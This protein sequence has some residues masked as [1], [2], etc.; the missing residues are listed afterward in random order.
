MADG[1][2][3]PGYDHRLLSHLECRY[4]GP[5]PKEALLWA[6]RDPAS[7]QIAR[8]RG[9]A[10]AFRR[11]AEIAILILRRHPN[12]DMAVGDLLRFRA[13]FR[14][15]NRAA[16]RLR[17]HQ[18]TPLP[19]TAE[20]YHSSLLDAILGPDPAGSVRPTPRAES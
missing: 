10:H 12:D 17:R 15:W 5:I 8:F 13:A 3:L 4:D 7:A 6:R 19:K 9:R 18:E 14:T 16:W 2:F 20:A 11:L 1:D